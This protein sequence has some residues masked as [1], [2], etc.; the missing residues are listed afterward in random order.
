MIKVRRG[1]Y[2]VRASI[3]SYAERMRVAAERAGNPTSTG[4]PD[5]LKAE[6]LKLTAAQREAQEMKNSAARADLVP[7]DEVRRGW[8]SILADVRAGMLAVP[9]RL[10]DLTPDQRA[11]LDSEIRLAL[12][13][14]SHG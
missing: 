6:K 13:R 7:A 4:D 14:L 8:E 3:K 1:V 12:E 2:D 9:A 11:K 10:S 5:A